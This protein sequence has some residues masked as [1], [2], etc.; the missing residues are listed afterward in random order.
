[1]TENDERCALLIGMADDLGCPC[2][3]LPAALRHKVFV[4]RSVRG[5]LA[6]ALTDDLTRHSCPENAQSSATP[7]VCCLEREKSER[8]LDLVRMHAALLLPWLVTNDPSLY[9]VMM[10]T[11]VPRCA[12]GSRLES[13]CS[14]ATLIQI[15][16]EYKAFCSSIGL[17]LVQHFAERT[18]C[19]GS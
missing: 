3:T 19:R 6:A 7:G 11:P 13:L 1:M 17:R 10:Q 5:T 14:V 8:M 4:V 16:R 2:A 12:I 18:A 9:K 15:D